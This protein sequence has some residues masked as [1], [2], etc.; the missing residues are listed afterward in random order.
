MADPQPS[1]GLPDVA[2]RCRA[3]LDHGATLLVEAG[4]GTGKTALMAGRIALLLAGGVP[5]REIVAITFTEAASSELLDRIG[6]FVDELKRG[7]IPVDLRLVLPAGLA[8]EQAKAIALAANTL[9]ELTC[10]TIHGFC[11]QLVKPYPVEAGI[12]P[13]AEIIDPAAAD[14]AYQDLVQAWLSARFGRDRG[15]EGLGRLPRLPELG[16]EDFFAELLLDEPDSVVKLILDTAAF[17]RTNRTAT[18]RVAD[19]ATGVL[20]ALSQSIGGFTDWYAGC[21]ITE[22]AT[23]EIIVD[24]QLIKKIVDEAITEPMTGRRLA[25]FTYGLLARII[26]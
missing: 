1:N 17:V 6:R 5:A 2:A 14:L 7:Q 13:G 9:D 24:L 23:N 22:S 15:A 8:T 18:A 16:E 19:M 4:A 20:D 10:T 21:G 11:Q 3:L 12:D 25:R 26:L